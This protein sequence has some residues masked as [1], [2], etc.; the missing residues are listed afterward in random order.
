MLARTSNPSAPTLQSL[1]V[2]GGETLAEHV[3]DWVAE[4]WPRPEVGLVV[5]AT[6]LEEIRSLRSR[7]P[8]PAF[9][10]PGLGAQG[11]DVEAAVRCCH[12]QLAPGLVN[13]SRGIAGPAAKAVD[14]Q[15]AAR[16]AAEEWRARLAEA[17]ATLAP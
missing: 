5:G 1:P 11:G 2:D 13:V 9:L 17:G 8:G 4:R 15:A 12:G 6:A 14:W 7:L 3:G 16:R 10:V